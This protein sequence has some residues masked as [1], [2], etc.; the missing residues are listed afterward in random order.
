MHPKM[1]ESLVVASVPLLLVQRNTRHQ[2]K[3]RGSQRISA[4]RVPHRDVAGPSAPS[5]V[6][7][8]PV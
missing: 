2:F 8:N 1:S 7:G 3:I 4:F 5:V 6:P